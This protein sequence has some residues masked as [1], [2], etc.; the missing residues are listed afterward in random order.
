MRVLLLVCIL[1][2][3]FA[4]GAEEGGASDLGKALAQQHEIR[5]AI[6]A[7]D[8]KYSYLD[9]RRRRLVMASQDRLFVLADGKA[10]MS[11]LTVDGQVQAFNELKRLEALL[12]NPNEDNRQKCERTAMAGTR[13]QEV[14]CYTK[15]EQDRRADRAKDALMYRPACTQPGC[16]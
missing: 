10:S 14:V 11:E 4:V 13:R 9:N 15:D 8:A 5:A 7:R 2:L 3:S 6:D 1:V 16:I 12:V